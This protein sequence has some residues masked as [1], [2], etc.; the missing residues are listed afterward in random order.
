M[1]TM[2]G[3]LIYNNLEKKF[4]NKFNSQIENESVSL[5]LEQS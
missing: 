1:I 5:R 3:A 4:L 2:K